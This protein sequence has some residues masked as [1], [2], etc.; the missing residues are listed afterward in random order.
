MTKDAT[1]GSQTEGSQT[2]AVKK[3][4]APTY[5]SKHSFVWQYGTD[6]LE[7]L[8][9]GPGE[10]ILDLGCGTGHLTNKIA[11]AG[12]E[13]VGIDNSQAMIEQ[14]RKNFP[15]LRFEIADG[16]D[17]RFDEPFDA[18]FS[19]AAI[20]WMR[21]PAAVAASIYRALKPGGRFV[22]EFGGKGNLKAIKTALH[23]AS[24]AAGYAVSDDVAFRYYPSIGEYA[25]LLEGQGFRVASAAHFDR[26][27]RLSG[28]EQGL[29]NWLA[30]FADNVLEL[31]PADKLEEVLAETE[32]RLRAEAYRDGTWFADYRRIRVIAVKE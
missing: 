24:A 5:D 8:A 18:V 27:T 12:A 30:T 22:A 29:R 20:H 16:T 19:N 3:W 11:E 1:G 9:P 17:F 21:D 23:N 14:A 6:V 26:P 32:E 25:T 13:V 28:G 15:R 7:L 2:D 10:R 4:D 31:L